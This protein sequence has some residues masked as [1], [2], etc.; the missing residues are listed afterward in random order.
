MMRRARADPAA[1]GSGRAVKMSCQVQAQLFQ[2]GKKRG[3]CAA[4]N[5]SFLV[6]SPAFCLLNPPFHFRC[7]LF[8]PSSLFP[9]PLPLLGTTVAFFACS[10][11][12]NT[13]EP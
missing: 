11:I 3:R 2:A 5:R 6:A 7:L 12:R 9:C 1:L 10:E 8:Y 4:H 13:A